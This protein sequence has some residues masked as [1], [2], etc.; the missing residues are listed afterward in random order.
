MGELVTNAVQVSVGSDS[1]GAGVSVGLEAMDKRASF[2][3]LTG[4]DAPS[5]KGDEQR[6]ATAFPDIIISGR[7]NQMRMLDPG[8][9]TT[10]TR[11]LRGTGD[12]A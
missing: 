11:S 9:L 2:G 8:L 7:T 6:H 3:V 5:E 1:L 12:S 10:G 4:T